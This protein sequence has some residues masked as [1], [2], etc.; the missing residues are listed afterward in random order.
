MLLRCH[1]VKHVFYMGRYRTR[2][3][4]IVYSSIYCSKDLYQ[5]VLNG[6]VSQAGMNRGFR[7]KDNEMVTYTQ[8]RDAFTYFYPKRQG[9]M[10]ANDFKTEKINN[11]NR[12]RR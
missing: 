1:R 8:W 11:H 2:A 3:L 4:K 5:R 12:Q 9:H 10:T 6:K 7:L